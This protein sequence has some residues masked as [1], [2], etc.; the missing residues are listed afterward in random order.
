VETQT[1]QLKAQANQV[2]Q[3]LQAFKSADERA[4]ETDT[5]AKAKIELL[6]QQVDKFKQDTEK[7][8]EALQQ[9]RKEALGAKQLAVVINQRP[10]SELKL[11]SRSILRN[12]LAT[13][14]PKPKVTFSQHRTPPDP[15]S[16][17]DDLMSYSDEEM[18]VEQE[19][20]GD[21][22]KGKMV[23][24]DHEE[25][26]SFVCPCETSFNIEQI[27]KTPA[28]K[29]STSSSTGPYL[30][31]NR[32]SSDSDEDMQAPIQSVPPPPVHIP[33]P[34]GGA[35]PPLTPRK[36]PLSKEAGRTSFDSPS[37]EDSFALM[38]ILGYIQRHDANNSISSFKV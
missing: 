28:P 31:V 37:Q 2:E 17:D 13:N 25:V 10:A 36:G 7:S 8:N 24:R 29:P 32:D 18:S 14:T 12:S 11:P 1:G 35:G 15:M 30:R 33:R 16:D 20:V 38:V 22:G 34:R 5:T 3:L 23:D 26:R 27:S 21:K 4:R 9:A 19:L 6:T